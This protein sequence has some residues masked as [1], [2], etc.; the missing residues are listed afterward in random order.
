MAGIPYMNE[1]GIS[2]KNRCSADQDI[3]KV[4]TVCDKDGSSVRKGSLYLM[5]V[6]I[7]F[8]HPCGMNI[9]SNYETIQTDDIIDKSSNIDSLIPMQMNL[10]I[11]EAPRFQRTMNK[12]KK[13]SDW[14]KASKMSIH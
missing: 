4:K 7:N 6:G 13:G 10:S 11:E 12:A 5:A 3:E 1:E 2:S 9:H 8:E 14:L